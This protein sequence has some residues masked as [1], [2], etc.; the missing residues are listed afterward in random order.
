MRVHQVH[1]GIPIP[2]LARTCT[3]PPAP[4]RHASPPGPAGPGRRPSGTVVSSFAP[5]WNNVAAPPPKLGAPR[6]AWELVCNSCELR[7][8]GLYAILQ[9]TAR[10]R[11]YDRRVN[12]QHPLPFPFSFHGTLSRSWARLPN[13]SGWQRALHSSWAPCATSLART[14]RGDADRHTAADS[15][16][17]EQE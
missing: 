12:S 13:G 7:Q 16:A 10:L 11:A 2:I 5:R 6:V 3:V 14:V 15:S 4:T 8:S 1:C 9:S 17:T